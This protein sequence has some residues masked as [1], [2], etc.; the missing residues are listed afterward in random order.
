MKGT[1]FYVDPQIEHIQCTVTP[2][3]L[4]ESFIVTSKVS[5]LEFTVSLIENTSCQHFH[6]ILSDCEGVV[7]IQET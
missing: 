5:F 3:V 7:C 2:F 6:G 1:L 4:K